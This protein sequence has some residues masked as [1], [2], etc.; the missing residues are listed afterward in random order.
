VGLGQVFLFVQGVS[1]R[2]Y[3]SLFK[4]L[5]PLLSLRNGSCG[6]YVE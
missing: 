4:T 1:K 2:Y 6:K 3:E 5:N